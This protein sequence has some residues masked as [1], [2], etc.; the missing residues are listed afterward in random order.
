MKK[1][2][3]LSLLVLTACTSPLP[4]AVTRQPAAPT[5]DLLPG[6]GAPVRA[7]FS[8]GEAHLVVELLAD[9]LAHLEFSYGDPAPVDTDTIATTVMVA[10]TD[11]TGPSAY[12]IEDNTLLTPALTVQVD[13]ASLCVTLIDSERNPALTLTTLC[14]DKLVA[15]IKSIKLTRESFTHVY[16]LG[17]KFRQP[18]ETASDWNGDTRIPGEFGNIMEP[19]NYC[20]AGNTQMP[21]AYFLGAGDQAYA[22]FLDNPHAQYWNFSKEPWLVNIDGSSPVR[23]Y[24]MSGPDLNDLRQDYLDL[25]GHPPVP[26]KPAFGLWVSEYGYDSWD[27]LEDK[28]RSLRQNGFPVDGFVLDLQWYGGIQSNSDDTRMGTLDWDENA[29]PNAADTLARLLDDEGVR[30]MTI[31]QS[32]IGKNLPEHQAMAEAGFLVKTC[33]DCEPVYL[34]DNPW[35]GKGGMIDWSNPQA[36]AWWHDNKRQP[37][38]DA[39]V[40]AHWTD[41]GEPELFS[42]IGWYHGIP[43]G[44]E[45]LRFE[46]DV[47]NLY[48]LLWSQSIYEGYQRNNVAQRP[49]ILTRSGTAGSQRYGVAMWSGDVCSTMTTQAAWMNTQMHLSLSGIDYYGSDIGGFYRKGEGGNTGLVADAYFDEVYTR[50]FAHSALLDVPIRP[51]TI[52]LDNNEET[53]PDRIGNT[54]SNLANLRLRYALSPYYYSLAHRAW[55]AGEAVIAPPV[56][57]YPQDANLREMGAQKMI[58]R[59]LMAITATNLA[60]TTA[61]GYLP[62]GS[63]IDFYAHTW[64]ESVGQEIGPVSVMDGEVFRLPLYVRAGAI[65]PLM[66]VDEQSMNLMGMRRDG[67]QVDDLI[68]RVYASEEGT[69][70]TLYEDDGLTT[71]YQRGALRRTP[72][73]QQMQDGQVRV[74]IGGAVGDYDGAP[75]VRGWQVEVHTPT[76]AAPASVTLDGETLTKAANLD[77]LGLAPRGWT[78]DGA[79]LIVKTGSLPVDAAVVIG[80]DY[81]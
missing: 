27:E 50:W 61:R 74:M 5:A 51:H 14:P 59:D 55:L 30:I 21:V 43:F 40:F 2:L 25:T 65:L 18:G 80:A 33:E 26:P 62:A 17:Q 19:F 60:A 57:Y 75:A 10:K 12:R 42:P 28:L 79:V 52:N 44:D 16:G 68:L 45:T 73:S 34:T 6:N 64:I 22:L 37:L 3:I 46:D 4:T 36:A 41:L 31:E 47:H 72:F 67:S 23:L 69:T 1:L 66:P 48:N 7:V 76:G 29:F 78:M 63:W 15:K 24:V 70:F 11:F 38:I 13:T 20:F 39:G 9:D 35:W 53:A 81:R 71:A 54:A 77:A 56:L 58:G 8:S 32:Y 49:F